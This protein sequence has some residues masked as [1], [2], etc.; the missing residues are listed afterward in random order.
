MSLS[1]GISTIKRE[2][3][4]YLLKT[5]GSLVNET[6]AHERNY[7]TI[8][9]M[10]A[11]SDQ[12]YNEMLLSRIRT[13]FLHELTS[14]FLLIIRAPLEHYPSLANLRTTFGDSQK[15]VAW[16]SKQNLDYATLM[17]FSQN[18]SKYYLQLEDDVIAGPSYYRSI[19]L[20]IGSKPQEWTMLDFSLLGFIGKLYRSR[21]LMKIATLLYTYFNEQPCDFLLSHHLR[22]MMQ[23]ERYYRKPTLFKHTG[24][25][26]SLPNT[27]RN[28]KNLYFR[29]RTKFHNGDNPE[30]EVQ[31]NMV[32]YHSYLPNL[33]YN[34]DFDDSG[35]WAVFPQAG[36]IIELIFKKPTN[37]S[38][39]VVE[40]GF[41]DERGRD[42]LKSGSLNAGY[43]VSRGVDLKM[44]CADFRPL[45]MFVKGRIDVRVVQRSSQ[46][47][48]LVITVSATQTQWL[49][50]P[51]IAVFV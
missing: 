51:E 15:R 33:A 3:N 42:S 6:S 24:I 29:G 40:T 25:Y 26:S 9:V 22:L 21:D 36:D 11:D 46:V 12:L 43:N 49:Y 34:H 28:N 38:R 41:T 7:I 2:H 44:H 27:T 14:G 5:I 31:S 48:C 4:L 17:A 45:G 39:I 50:V 19:M 16:R 18:V 30:A 1:I 23:K 47:R 10:F 35:F 32:V 13:R 8:V 20:Y 37:I